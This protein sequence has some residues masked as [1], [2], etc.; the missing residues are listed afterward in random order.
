MCSVVTEQINLVLK[1]ALLKLSPRA[2]VSGNWKNW[3]RRQFSD[4]HQSLENMQLFLPAI[5]LI[6]RYSKEVIYTDL[7]Q[8]LLSQLYL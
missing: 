7:L 5:A 3:I 6:E 1:D 8:D 2:G 4:I